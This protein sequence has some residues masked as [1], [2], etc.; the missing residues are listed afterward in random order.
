MLTCRSSVFL[1]M[2]V[3]FSCLAFGSPGRADAGGG[4]RAGFSS[5]PD[6]FLIGGQLELAPIAHNL[7]IIPSG[8][9]GFGDNLTTVSFNGDLQY[10]FD[11]HSEVRFYA[12]GG[13]AVYLAN[14]DG[15][16][17]SDTNFGV[18]ALGG[19]F[20][21]RKSSSPMFVELKAG[22]ADKVPDW[23]AVFGVNFR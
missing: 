13:V 10:R 17:G 2:T 12:G 5:S 18:N 4:L 20:F 11:S 22:L 16:V 9:L 3:V 1:C 23:K 21:N 6:Q 7:Y 8:E 19:I 14:P 15:P